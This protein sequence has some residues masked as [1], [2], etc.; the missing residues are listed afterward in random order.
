LIV[1]RLDVRI[2]WDDNDDDNTTQDGWKAFYSLSVAEQQLAS[3]TSSTLEGWIS[4][5]LPCSSV[6]DQSHPC[7]PHV[8]VEAR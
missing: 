5:L 2:A 4:P 8:C 1:A 6:L 3:S 7:H